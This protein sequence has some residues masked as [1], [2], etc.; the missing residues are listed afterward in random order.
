M[1]ERVRREFWGYAAGETFSPAEHL[2]QSGRDHEA[3]DVIG[4]AGLHRRHEVR[5]AG[6]GAP[7][8]EAFAERMHERVRREFWGYAAGETFSPAELVSD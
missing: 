3:A 2:L 4:E 8:A 5:Q 6:I 1:H 7:I